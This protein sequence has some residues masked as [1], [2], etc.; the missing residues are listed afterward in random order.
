MKLILIYIAAKFI[1]QFTKIALNISLKI[2]VTNL[3]LENP[4][5]NKFSPHEP[6]ILLGKGIEKFVNTHTMPRYNT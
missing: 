2:L 4:A 5:M 1:S 3:K 6:H